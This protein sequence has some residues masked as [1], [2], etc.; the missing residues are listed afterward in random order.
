MMS[1]SQFFLENIV[2]KVEII[3]ILFRIPANQH[4]QPACFKIWCPA[5]ATT[6][7]VYHSPSPLPFDL[8]GFACPLFIMPSGVYIL[9]HE[10]SSCNNF[11]SHTVAK[12]CTIISI[13]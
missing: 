4:L 8:A 13:G 10:N 6:I 7:S 11:G 3:L 2:Q 5:A 9:Q 1:P 12:Y